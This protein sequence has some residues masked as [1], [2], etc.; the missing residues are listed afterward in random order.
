MNQMIIAKLYSFVFIL[1]LAFGQSTSSMSTNDILTRFVRIVNHLVNH[2]L[3]YHCKSADDDLGIRTL[4]PNGKWEF[5]FDDATFKQTDFY[6]YFF[7]EHFYAAFDVFIEDETTYSQAS[8]NAAASPSPLS[9]PS[10]Q[11]LKV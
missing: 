5:S 11:F 1:L 3:T 8:C 2:P 9:K 4:Q 10:P 6:C 7:N